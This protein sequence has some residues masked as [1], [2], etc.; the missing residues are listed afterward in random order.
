[1]TVVPSFLEDQSL[2]RSEL[3]GFYGIVVMANK[4]CKEHDVL[5][6]GMEIGG[7]NVKALQRAID[8]DYFISSNHTHFNL[9]TVL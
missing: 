4:I 6:G 5:E 8:L 7:D 3:E 9:T 1:M 2:L